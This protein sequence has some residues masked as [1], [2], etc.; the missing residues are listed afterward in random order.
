MKD[1]AIAQALTRQFATKTGHTPSDVSK[2][3]IG[4]Y[5]KI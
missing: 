5:L 2:E 3:G 4:P 1:G